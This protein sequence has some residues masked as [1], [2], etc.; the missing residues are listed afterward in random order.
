[1]EHAEE[2]L[3]ELVIAGC[4]RAVDLKVAEHTLDAVAQSVEVLVPADRSLA[5]GTRWYDRP[6]ATRLKIGPD[7]IAIVALVAEHGLGLRLGQIDQ[8]FVAPAI[9]PLSAC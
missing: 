3:G 5:V 7:R 6:N 8:D 4:N 2:T 1:M 9:R